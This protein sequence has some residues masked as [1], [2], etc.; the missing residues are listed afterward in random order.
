MLKFEGNWRFDNPG[1]LQPEMENAFRDLI[2]KICAQGIRQELLE[3][4]KY[5]FSSKAGISYSPSSNEGWAETDLA[6]AMSTARENAPLF[7]EAFHDACEELET[8]DPEMDL[9]GV[10]RINRILSE[11]GAGFQIDPPRL[12]ATGGH[13]PINVPDELPSLDSQAKVAIEEALDASERALRER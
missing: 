13:M 12:V 4:F 1:A 9:P 8:S 3:H 11:G 5:H 2:D 6:W 10:G 7:I